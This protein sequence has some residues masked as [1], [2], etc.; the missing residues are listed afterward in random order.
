MLNNS[1]SSLIFTWGNPSRGDDALGPQIYEQLQQEVPANV[2][3]LTDFQLQIEHA[4]DLENRQR[5]LFVDASVAATEPFEFYR[6]QAIQD[7]SYSTHAVSPQSLLAVYEK[8]NHNPA[9][10][11]FMLSIRGYQFDLGLPVS[12]KAKLNL[13]RAISFIKRLA[14]NNNT[15]NWDRMTS[16]RVTNGRS[17][18]KGP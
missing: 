6:L 16:A 5:V 8:I 12:S 1:S 4:V 17:P 11:A 9:P 15:D 7:E 10:P 18:D 13:E 14:V 2:D 3:L